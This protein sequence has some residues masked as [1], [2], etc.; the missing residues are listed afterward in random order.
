M[1]ILSRMSIMQ[2]V[3]AERD[4]IYEKMERRKVYGR[5][6]PEDDQFPGGPSEL[7]MRCPD[8]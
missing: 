1:Y 5:V 3:T 6:I 2:D 4:E 7:D 8:H